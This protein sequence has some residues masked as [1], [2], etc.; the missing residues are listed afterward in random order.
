MHG[1]MHGVACAA[2]TPAPRWVHHPLPGDLSVS[3]NDRT[4]P[5]GRNVL[6]VAGLTGLALFAGWCVLD[7]IHVARPGRRS[8]LALA[9]LIGVPAAVVGVF[10]IH[11]RVFGRKR[12]AALATTLSFALG[13]LLFVT[14]GGAFH[15]AIGGSL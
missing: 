5:P 1:T 3:T 6:L 4:G 7:W 10:W 9:E 12:T 14:V 13:L 15:L 11:V 8:G 2:V